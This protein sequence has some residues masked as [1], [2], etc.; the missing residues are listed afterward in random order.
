MYRL[1]EQM[2]EGCGM[3]REKSYLYLEDEEE[4][5]KLSAPQTGEGWLRCSWKQRQWALR[6][7]CDSLVNV[8]L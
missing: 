3:W 4:E 2:E 6:L 8:L 5:E 1:L 7:A